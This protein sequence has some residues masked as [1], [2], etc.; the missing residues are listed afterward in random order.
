MDQ[1]VPERH[2]EASR[3]QP[4][5]MRLPLFSAF[6]TLHDFLHLRASVGFHL[7]SDSLHSHQTETDSRCFMEERCYILLQVA[8]ALKAIMRCDGYHI[9]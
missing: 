3:D 7:A 6:L 2:G 9:K 1:S 4:S 8:V 5:Q